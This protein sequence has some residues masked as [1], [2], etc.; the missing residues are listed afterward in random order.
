MIHYD[1]SKVYVITR[2]TMKPNYIKYYDCTIVAET[3]RFLVFIASNSEGEVSVL[4]E[5]SL[6]EVYKT[7]TEKLKDDI[8]KDWRQTGSLDL[9]FDDLS[10]R[11]SIGVFLDFL[12]REG[13]LCPDIEK[14]EG[15]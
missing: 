5:T 10:S 2:N 8:L 13:Y 4:K 7:T 12:L 15:C 6:I 14:E 1:K 9:A 11:V 3:E